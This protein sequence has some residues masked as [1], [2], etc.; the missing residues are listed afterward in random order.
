MNIHYLFILSGKASRFNIDS[1]QI[2]MM[3][4]FKVRGSA[5]ILTEENYQET[6]DHVHNFR[7]LIKQLRQNPAQKYCSNTGRLLSII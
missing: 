1:L 7:A 3:N 6:Q 2:S 4:H 5:Q